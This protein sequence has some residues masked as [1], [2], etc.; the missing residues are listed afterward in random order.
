M[1]YQP[2]LKKLE[3]TEQDKKISRISFL[4]KL[5]KL[6]KYYSTSI[7]KD[8]VSFLQQIEKWV[9]DKTIGIKSEKSIPVASKN[10]VP[11]EFFNIDK[12]HSTIN[13]YEGNLP[14][15]L[16]PI[17]EGIAGDLIVLNLSPENDGKIY[18]WYH[19]HDSSNDGLYLLAKNFNEFI[20]KLLIVPES[21]VTT[22]DVSIVWESDEFLEMLK[23]RTT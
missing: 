21:D 13:N 11:V 9:F 8:Y 3:G 7:P 4:E 18:Y 1:N 5:E 15:N 22:D 10:I 14:N 2:I 6:E 12:I 23:D 16:L 20:K 17:A 19:E